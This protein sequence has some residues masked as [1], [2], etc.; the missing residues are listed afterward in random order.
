MLLLIASTT[1]MSLLFLLALLIFYRTSRHRKN[2]LLVLPVRPTIKLLAPLMGI[3]GIAAVVD[4][5]YSFLFIGCILSFMLIPFSIDIIVKSEGVY[6]GLKFTPWARIKKISDRSFCLML[7]TDRKI[8]RK[9]FLKFI[10]QIR[11]EDIK[12][13]ESLAKDSKGTLF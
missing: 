11:S 12:Q 2:A 3:L 9:G 6:F 5:P 4:F 10:W 7:T 1:L 13:I 8:E